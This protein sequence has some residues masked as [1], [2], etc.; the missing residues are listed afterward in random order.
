M[1]GIGIYPSVIELSYVM[2]SIFYGITGSF[3][4]ALLV[5]L[6]LIPGFLAHPINFPFSD[7]I[8]VAPYMD[9]FQKFVVLMIATILAG[10]LPA[11]SIVKQNTLNAILGR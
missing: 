9:T 5:Y 2:Q 3:I 8:M 10:Y 7:G 11:R 4:G 1:K 6:V